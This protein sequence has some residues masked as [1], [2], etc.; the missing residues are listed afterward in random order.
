VERE[1]AEQELR[2]LVVDD[3]AVNRRVLQRQL[4]KERVPTDCAC[5]GHE[6]LEKVRTGRYGLVFMD[7]HMPLMGGCEAVAQIRALEAQGGPSPSDAAEGLRRRHTIV[8]LSGS[9]SDEA[10]AV[11]LSQGADEFLCKPVPSSQV[12]GI[13]RKYSRP[14]SHPAV[15]EH[16]GPS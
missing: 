3:D 2:A 7:L 5:N 11:C 6:A 8:A 4:E 13:V 14:V 16:P 10:A 1:E 9:T 12:R 15:L